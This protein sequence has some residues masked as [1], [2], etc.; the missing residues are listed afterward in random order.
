MSFKAHRM[1]TDP[2][3]VKRVDEPV[4][5]DHTYDIPFIAGYSRDGKTIYI[6]RHFPE[7]MG[8]VDIVPYLLTHEKTE[9]ALIDVFGLDYQ[10]AHHLATH[11]ERVHT[12]KDGID[13]EKY[14]KHCTS[15][16]KP[17]DHE[18][19]ER[20]PRDLDLTPYRDEKDPD[21]QKLVS[22]MK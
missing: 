8:K 5:I 15:Y 12:D 13:W 7:K 10:Q 14:E 21:Y 4:K 11:A 9:K 16:E 6:D 18:K 22:K 20:V 1:L 2:R 17:L 19:I 3:V